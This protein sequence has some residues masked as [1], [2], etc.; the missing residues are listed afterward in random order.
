MLDLIVIGA[1]LCGLSAALAAAQAGLSVRI[2][3]K[4]HGATHWTT[5]AL[6][7]L[8]YMPESGDKVNSP[9]ER[10]CDL[11]AGHPYTLVGGEGVHAAIELLATTLAAEGLEYA[12]AGQPDANLWLP[13]PIGAARPT[14]LAPRGQIDGDLSRDEPIVIVGLRGLRDFYPRLIAENLSKQGIRARAEFLPLDLITARRDVNSVQLANALEDAQRQAAL[15]AALARIVRPGERIG[16]P[17]LLGVEHHPQ[18]L[19]ALQSQTQASIFEIPT[20]PPSV[21][22][23]RLYHALARAF[24]RLDVRLETNMEVIGFVAEDR[25]IRW[26]ETAASARPLRH[27]AERFLLATGGILGGGFNSDHRGRFWE[28]VFDLPITGV[29]QD[30]A[31]WLRPA[32]L[33]PKGHA[34]FHAGIAV[35]DSFRPVAENGE[36]VYTNLWAAGALLAHA[37]PIRERSLEGIAVATGVT[38]ERQLARS[39]DMAT[40]RR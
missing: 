12:G 23:L 28:V 25:R 5:G 31:E 34:V 17:A 26:I 21:P 9:I 6:D 10:L 18:A 29:P 33:D 39:V 19:D 32:F 20:L 22:G 8:G 11:P 7:V 35:D 27:H 37:D 30:R 14:F 38:A 1:G 24:R 13:S 40:A 2:V 16:L 15:A 4:G 3:A 36:P